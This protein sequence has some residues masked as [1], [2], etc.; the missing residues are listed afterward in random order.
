MAVLLGQIERSEAVGILLL[1]TGTAIEQHVHDQTL[2]A[3]A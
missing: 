3:S 2:L 1:N